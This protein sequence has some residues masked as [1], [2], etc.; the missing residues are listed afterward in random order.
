M[1]GISLLS[2]G[3]FLF[4]LK[5]PLYLDFQTNLF[6]DAT[7]DLLLLILFGLQ[8]SVMARENWKKN[9]P[10][11]IERTTYVLFSGLALLLLTCLWQPIPIPIWTITHPIEVFVMYAIG[12][13]GLILSV[14]SILAIDPFSLIGLRQSGILPQK[15]ETFQLGH[16]HSTIRHPLYTGMIIL[17]WSTPTM[18]VGHLMFAMGMTIYIRIG[19]HFEEKTLCKQFG[20]QYRTYQ[21]EVPMLFPFGKRTGKQ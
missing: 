9:I 15:T 10:T 3:A 7:I 14:G 4:Q 5:A 13:L 18:N 16:L 11:S 20:E 12:L 21:N 19:I 1:S 17:F 8:H 6:I 2:L